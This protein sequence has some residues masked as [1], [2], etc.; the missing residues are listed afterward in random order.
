MQNLTT[1]GDQISKFIRLFQQFASNPQHSAACQK[2]FFGGLVNTP[3]FH[4]GMFVWSSLSSYA[5][6]YADICFFFVCKKV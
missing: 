2:I 6:I 4:L 3:N 5:E 1:V